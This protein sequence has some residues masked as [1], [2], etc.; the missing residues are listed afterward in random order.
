MITT[1]IQQDWPLQHWKGMTQSKPQTIINREN[2]MLWY[3]IIVLLLLSWNYQ[4]V[5]IIIDTLYNS[6]L[7]IYNNNI[8]YYVNTLNNMGLVERKMVNYM[9]PTVEQVLVFL[10]DKNYIKNKTVDPSWVIK[11]ILDQWV[12][13][14]SNIYIWMVWNFKYVWISIITVY[15]LLN[16]Y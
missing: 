6:L 12:R 8:V 13:W 5:L 2:I 10:P 15:W 3:I 16:Y 7:L 4:T 9:C 1:I 11:L 14:I